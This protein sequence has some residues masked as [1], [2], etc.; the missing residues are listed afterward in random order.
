MMFSKKILK[1]VLHSWR[2]TIT[3][4]RNEHTIENLHSLLDL[5]DQI[6]KVILFQIDDESSDDFFSKPK[7]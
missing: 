4:S 3:V 5:F 7:F 6:V 1:N 2:E